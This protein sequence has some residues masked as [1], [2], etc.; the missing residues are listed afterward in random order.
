M[1]SIA[2]PS[3]PTPPTDVRKERVGLTA[4]AVFGLS[5]VILLLAFPLLR[6]WL[7]RV[8]AHGTPTWSRQ[9]RTEFVM[10]V[11]WV[12]IVFEVVLGVSFSSLLFNKGLQ[13]WSRMYAEKAHQWLLASADDAIKKD[14]T[15][16]MYHGLRKDLAIVLFGTP[17]KEYSLVE[18]WTVLK[19][20]YELQ[21]HIKHNGLRIL[22][23]IFW[24]WLLRSFAGGFHGMIAAIAFL[25][26][27][28][29][30]ALK[31]MADSPV[32]MG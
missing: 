16:E 26:V 25:G 4:L 14:P 18:L 21:Q 9:G 27:L 8:A 6:D 10:W 19:Q 3:P 24:A 30:K 32:W 5:A 31:Q 15:K 13:D 2:P 7:I 11:E 12:R 28:T 17:I 22:A 1:A 23:T 29:T 20:G